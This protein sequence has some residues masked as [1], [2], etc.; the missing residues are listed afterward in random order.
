MC[1]K[2][3]AYHP[4]YTYT[5]EGLN[6]M[7]FCKNTMQNDTVAQLEIN[8][9]ILANGVMKLYKEDIK[10]SY[11]R[12]LRVVHPFTQNKT[13]FVVFSF[14]DMPDSQDT[15]TTYST[16][17]ILQ[18]TGV[19]NCGTLFKT[20]KTPYIMYMRKDGYLSEYNGMA[21]IEQLRNYLKSSSGSCV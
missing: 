18:D 17:V 1:D 14:H 19:M 7:P 15:K 6:T 12:R 8:R 13:G 3:T 21:N 4:H 9:P 2:Y 16:F 11:G 20:C 5:F 10:I